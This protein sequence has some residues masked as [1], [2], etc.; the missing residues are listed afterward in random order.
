MNAGKT[1]VKKVAD[2]REIANDLGADVLSAWN[3]LVDRLAVLDRH[4]R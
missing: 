1:Q 4:F 2:P 3:E